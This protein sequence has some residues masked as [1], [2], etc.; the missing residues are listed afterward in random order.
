MH[1]FEALLVTISINF[2]RFC[3]SFR[4]SF[5]VIKPW[6]ACIACTT[7]FGCWKAELQAL[8]VL[9]HAFWTVLHCSSKRPDYEQVIPRMKEAVT[10]VS[11]DLQKPM[12]DFRLLQF[13]TARTL[14]PFL[15]WSFASWLVRF[16]FLA[17]VVPLKFP[18]K[19]G[20]YCRRT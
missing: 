11:G 19:R 14:H 13:E 6:M 3:P 18:K 2:P 20:N 4:V 12:C 7:G 16:V 1:T 15:L 17:I 10:V 9:I 5:P 8:S